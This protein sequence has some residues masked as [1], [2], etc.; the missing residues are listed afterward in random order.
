MKRE[1]PRSKKKYG[2][3]DGYTRTR[4]KIQTKE[5]AGMQACG[6]I[7]IGIGREITHGRDIWKGV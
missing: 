3:V 2:E 5:N 7:I 4:D 6:D 1:Y